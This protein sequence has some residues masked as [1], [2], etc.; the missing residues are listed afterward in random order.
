MIVSVTVH[1][2]TLQ[3]DGP[4]AV[5]SVYL[6]QAVH[7]LPRRLCPSL[8][9]DR[10]TV[11]ILRVPCRAPSDNGGSD[12]DARADNQAQNGILPSTCLVAAERWPR[13]DRNPRY[14]TAS[15]SQG[16]LEAHGVCFWV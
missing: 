2:E 9:Y 6:L 10:L 8:Y 1:D 5:R 7:G 13:R 12:H 3:R 4:A 16:L 11:Q 14:R 15:V